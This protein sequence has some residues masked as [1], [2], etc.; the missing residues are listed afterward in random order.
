LTSKPFIGCQSRR[1]SP[2]RACRPCL[3]ALEERRLLTGTVPSGN[4]V[5]DF[6]LNSDPSKPGWDVGGAFVEQVTHGA[7]TEVITDPNKVE[8]EGWSLD[9]ETSGS[10]NFNLD[11]QESF[12]L[13]SFPRLMP[14]VHV[15]G[16]ALDV[17]SQK[18]LV[19]IA[20][21]HGLYNTWVQGNETQHVFVGEELVLSSGLEIGAI[22]GIEVAPAPP[23][24]QSFYGARVDNLTILVVP[25]GPANRPPVARDDSAT[26]PPGQSVD[27]PVLDNDY[28]PDGDLFHIIP[29]GVGTPSHGSAVANSSGDIVYT[30]DPSFHGTDSFAYSIEDSHGATASGEV[31]V[32]VDNPPEAQTGVYDLPH[33]SSGALAVPSPDFPGLLDYARDADD[34]PLTVVPQTER[35]TRGGSVTIRA[36][37]S[38][39]YTPPAGVIPD[40]YSGDSFTYKVNDGLVDSDPG[41]VYVRVKDLAP[42]AGQFASTSPEVDY[43]FD[44]PPPGSTVTYEGGPL[45][46]SDPEGDPLTYLLVSPPAYGILTL[47][48]DGRFTYDPYAIDYSFQFKVFDGALYSEVATVRLHVFDTPPIALD[49]NYGTPDIGSSEATPTIGSGLAFYG[50]DP[51]NAVGGVLPNIFGPSSVLSNDIDAENDQLFAQQPLDTTQP[52]THGY[53]TLRPDGSFTYHLFTGTFFRGEL[54]DEFTYVANDGLADSQPAKVRLLIEP[55]PLALD[56]T[57]TLRNQATQD[58]AAPSILGNDLDCQGRFIRTVP[59]GYFVTVD[60]FD[61]A[62][63]RAVVLSQ[64]GELHIEA[65]PGFI[66]LTSFTYHITQPDPGDPGRTIQSPEATVTVDVRLTP[67]AFPGTP[68]SPLGVPDEYTTVQERAIRPGTVPSVLANDSTPGEFPPTTIVTSKP[69]HA[70]SFTLQTNGQFLYAPQPGFSG[71]DEFFYSPV[72]DGV[73][74]DPTGVAIR[75]LADYDHDGIPD[76]IEQSAPN[77]GDADYDGIPDYI[78][79]NVASLNNGDPLY[80]LTLAADNARVGEFSRIPYPDPVPPEFVGVPA[81]FLSFQLIVPAPGASTK[82]T[83]FSSPLSGVTAHYFKFGS[84]PDNPALHWYEFAY[85][86]TTGAEILPAARA[87]NGM[88]IP[89]RLVLHLVDGGRGD[90]DGLANGVIQDPG[91]IVFRTFASP[92]AAFVISLHELVLQR[93]PSPEEL[94]LGERRLAAGVSRLRLARKVWESPEHRGMEV[95]RLYRTDLHRAAEPASRAYWVR[96]LERGVGETAVARQFL[97]SREYRHAHP[98]LR[99]FV[100]GV[101][102]DVLGRPPNASGRMTR[103]LLRLGRR[104]GRVALAQEVLGSRAAAA[105]LV[106]VDDEMFL[107]RAAHPAEVRRASNQLLIRPAAPGAI[108]E[109]ILASEA[110]YDLVNSALPANLKTSG[111]VRHSHQPER[112]PTAAAELRRRN[113]AVRPK[114]AD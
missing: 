12:Y 9:S 52:P 79:P 77:H 4:Y 45:P 10:T 84:T 75:V 32:V 43:A 85:D 13:A 53:V 58:I 54:E 55:R 3:D 97:T 22:R 110:F 74:G 60:S 30:A 94:A 91:A 100:G 112:I 80:N 65:I 35:T 101:E 71:D 105:R 72:Q 62:G 1:P 50:F 5:E 47:N 61:H 31:K 76:E 66:G 83:I 95:E 81:I 21:E 17:N 64:T 90:E 103:R 49:D 114:G 67:P 33:G 99:S 57:I 42:F 82:V 102:A 41:T 29:N 46:A 25:D 7:V 28:D 20:G 51:S 111:T 36:D 68:N 48:P 2:H 92:A 106:T 39:S 18:A 86:G 96:M 6:Q 98:S 69:S 38:F 88:M 24:G 8:G 16:I 70:A 93:E 104:A 59:N 109:R 37:G 108:A 113:W 14:G 27:I 26:V 78:E 23:S 34:D 15:A 87:S 63:L 73:T 107:G 40:P 19:Q 44:H 56:D 11:L 89:A